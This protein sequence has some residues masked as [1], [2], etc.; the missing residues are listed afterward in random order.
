LKDIE[1]FRNEKRRS[2]KEAVMRDSQPLGSVSIR[3]AYPMVTLGLTRA[4]EG[5]ARVYTGEASGVVPAT[6][7]ICAEDLEDVRTSIEDIKSTNP[8]ASILVF[9]MRVDLPLAR[10]A[11]R[12]GA[13]G[14][15]HAG[16]SPDQVAR[17]VEVAAR[18]EIVA[19]RQ[20]VEH[21]L[22]DEDPVDI[23]TLSVRQREVLGLVVEGLSNAQI[24]HQL[25]LSES[26]IK[27]HLRAAYKT[28]G[29]SNRNE[30]ARVMRGR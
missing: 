19:P 16:M 21:L 13:R 27:Q 26:T 4:L 15:I 1:S 14:F 7:I 24:A 23:E 30:A 5:H 10:T 2:V 6:V 28:L 22:A 11:F 9:G 12:A 29:V 3:C 8:E 18:G 20:L 17:A 25:Y